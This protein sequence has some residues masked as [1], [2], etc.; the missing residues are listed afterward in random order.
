MPTLRSSKSAAAPVKPVPVLPANPGHPAFSIV[1]I[2]ASAGGLEALER[3]LKNVPPACGLT[4]VVVQH[5]DPT[6]KGI[7]VELLQRAT[8]MQVLQIKDRM[9]VVPDRVYVIPPNHDLSILH[10]VLHLLEPAAPRGLRLPI[11]FFLRAL[12]ADQQER[13]IGVILSG[14][15]SD[16]TLGL[17]AIKEKAGAVFVQ[18]PASAKFDSM[19]GS[20][21]DAGLADVAAPAELT[22][23]KEEMQSMN[24]EW[25]TV[26]HE[27][28]AR[29]DELSRAG[30]DMKNLLN[31]NDIATLFLDEQLK[32]RRFTTQT[33]RII[34]LI[35]GDAGRPVTDLATEMDCPERAT[36]TNDVLRSLVFHERRVSA[37]DGR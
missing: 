4:F 21:V 23:S 35:P 26:N 5:L 30:D 27:L 37:R 13:S 11:D 29:L 31:G 36:D 16:G 33:T 7:M 19:P 22:T 34:E 1:G 17:C 3:F 2:G 8:A 25:Q 12:A 9:K 14:M 10:D 6:H 20:A 32:V 24:E 28:Q 15:G 18:T